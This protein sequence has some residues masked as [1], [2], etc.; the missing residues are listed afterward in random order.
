M[1]KAHDVHKKNFDMSKIQAST[2]LSVQTG[3]CSEDCAYCAQSIRNK[4]KLP[5]QTIVDVAEIVAAA[6]KAKEIG[7][8]RFCMGASGKKPTEEFFQMICRAVCEVK[9]LGLETCL[10]IGSLTEKQVIA[11]KEA[12][13]DYY[14]HNVDTSKE[15]YDKIITTRTIEE[16]LATITLVQK[17]KINVCSGGILGLGESNEDRIKM[18]LILANLEPQPQSVPINKLVKI[19]GT[20][21]AGPD[22]SFVDTLPDSPSADGKDVDNFDFIKT[23]ALCRILM[24]KSYVR[25]SAGRENMSD[26]MQAW[27]FFA[28]ANSIFI[29]EK[30]L[31]VAN[32]SLE[33]DAFLLKK[34][35]LEIC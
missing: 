32:A 28:G 13:L 17:H 15:F 5:K 21:L 25:L 19:K 22:D 31:T 11:L 23:I 18:L 34:L 3:G 35:S 20:K 30:L 14:N 4:T 8:S 12:G 16:R 27:C 29:G 2:L 26:E 7:S 9:K 1:E 10:T 24:P 6:K 33:R